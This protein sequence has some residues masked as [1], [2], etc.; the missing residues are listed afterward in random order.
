MAQAAAAAPISDKTK[1]ISDVR[2]LIDISGSMKKNDPQNL[3]IPALRL[4]T[5]LLPA[6][7][8]SGVWTFGKYVNMLVPYGDV[9]EGWKKKAGLAAVKINSVG[10]Y[11]N[12]GRAI[13]KATWNWATPNDK[14]NRSIILLTDGL[15]DIS[16]DQ[17]KNETERRRILEKSLVRLKKAG[18]TIHTIALSKEADKAFLNQLSATTSGWYEEVLDANQLERVFL[19]MFEKAVPVD[20]LP[21]EDNKV[22]FDD[23]I[24]EATLLIFR[25]QSAKRV[26]LVRPDGE[27][28]D[29]TTKVANINWRHEV[30]YDLVTITKPM[31]GEWKVIADLDPDNRVMVVTDLRMVNNE[32]P[33]VILAGESYPYYAELQQKS[34]LITKPEF[35]ALVKMEMERY[36]NGQRG[37]LT[38]LKDD[39]QKPDLRA[40][41][42]RFSTLVGEGLKAGTYEYHVL[43]DGMT[44]S[45]MHRQ[46]VRVVD[47]P[48]LVTAR[49]VEAGNPSLYMLSV[50]PYSEIVEMDGLLVN[51]DV[52]K[53]GGGSVSIS[54]PRV[55]PNE[56]RLDTEINK[57]DIFELDVSLK[58]KLHKS[59]KVGEFRLG[60]Y[61]FGNGEVSTPQG[62]VEQP[63]AASAG[64][65]A[66]AS[67]K[68][69]G[70]PGA[71]NEE[72][73]DGQ[74]AKGED[75]AEGERAAARMAGL[76]SPGEETGKKLF[77]TD[78]D[79]VAS[80]I[81]Q[82]LPEWFWVAF[83]VVMFN[84]VVIGLAYFVYRKWFKTSKLEV[85]AGL[86]KE[87]DA[88]STE[89]TDT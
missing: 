24:K 79:K 10:L 23:S 49:M 78:F 64:A 44:F 25:K 37:P 70:E 35:L 7:S 17:G 20:T 60:K 83:S 66:E 36:Q 1:K 42:G 84:L 81:N 54:I 87:D 62:K 32:L 82:S 27:R 53:S 5:Q 46:S 57:G 51:A 18:V 30:R 65:S 41:D 86:E 52:T 31:A 48:A 73:D 80:E 28:Y 61:I 26:E 58:A 74:Q 67:M 75:G 8:R 22:V 15:V 12:M 2:L 11:T 9:D 33:E 40:G 4:V 77:G 59:G 85:L 69:A 6:G 50:V 56:W 29:H 88:V 38:I 19:R 68:K 76:A 89:T 55:S 72:G 21:L 45:R 3:R 13:D 34:K 63:A 71:E 14:Y 39:G 43:A 16:K 47:V